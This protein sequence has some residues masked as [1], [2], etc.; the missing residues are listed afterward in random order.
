MRTDTE[1][2]CDELFGTTVLRCFTCDGISASISNC[3]V[4]LD[5]RCSVQT[6]PASCT[7]TCYQYGEITHNRRYS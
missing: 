6:K 1:Y 4:K 7:V 5:K 3:C 2:G